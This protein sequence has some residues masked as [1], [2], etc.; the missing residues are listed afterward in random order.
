MA[1]FEAIAHAELNIDLLNVSDVILNNCAHSSA[2]ASFQMGACDCIEIRPSKAHIFL[3]L[4]LFS[5]IYS[6]IQSASNNLKT[7]SE[8]T[9]SQLFQV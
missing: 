8:S 1:H 7:V 6:A 4:M 5:L 2:T 9:R 3:L